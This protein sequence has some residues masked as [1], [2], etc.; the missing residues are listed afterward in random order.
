MFLKTKLAL[1]EQ[2]FGVIY[3]F[4]LLIL[5]S[6]TEVQVTFHLGTQPL[7]R[8]KLQFP[9][10]TDTSANFIHATSSTHAQAPPICT[11][12]KGMSVFRIHL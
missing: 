8:L 6:T 3:T 1:T 5:F 12:L 2:Y 4:K 10:V 9:H 7:P 11:Q